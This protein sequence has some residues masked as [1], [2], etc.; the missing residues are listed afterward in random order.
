MLSTEQGVGSSGPDK[1][2]AS[3]IAT[4]ATGSSSTGA[5]AAPPPAKR[6][7][8]DQPH[9]GKYKLI[10]TLGSG[11]FAKVKLAQHITTKKEVRFVFTTLSQ[12]DLSWPDVIFTLNFS[13]FS[14][15]N[16]NLVFISYPPWD[17]SIFK[18]SFQ[19]LV[20][21]HWGY[22]GL[23]QQFSSI[24][25]LASKLVK[26]HKDCYWNSLLRILLYFWGE[27]WAFTEA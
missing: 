1:R 25:S 5:A 21:K 12:N 14:H 7:W 13:L 26:I 23:L 8:R 24:C 6:A 27:L 17:S 22:I 19:V 2:A 10:R 18:G 4:S 15:F 16:L 11:N 3:D 9:V 20:D